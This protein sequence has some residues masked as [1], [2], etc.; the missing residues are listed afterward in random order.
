MAYTRAYS[1]QAPVYNFITKYQKYLGLNSTTVDQIRN[2]TVSCGYQ[3][4]MDSITYPRRGKIPLPNDGNK[5]LI[6]DGC[7]VWDIYNN[8]AYNINPCF[9]H[10][11]ITTQ[12]PYMDPVE[13]IYYVE[14]IVPFKP[15]RSTYRQITTSSARMSKKHFTSAVSETGHSAQTAPFS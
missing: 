12:C 1:Q 15:I 4:L 13:K 8:A 2:A 14:K 9:S 6:T 5:D 7:D 10:Y 11:K 3:K